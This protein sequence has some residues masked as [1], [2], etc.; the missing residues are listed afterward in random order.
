M[1][2]FFKILLVFL[3]NYFGYILSYFS[4][5]DQIILIISY[6]NILKNL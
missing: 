4:I 1:S 3:L 5:N 6:D 2:L